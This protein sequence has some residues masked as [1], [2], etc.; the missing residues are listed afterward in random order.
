MVL[1]VASMIGVLATLDLWTQ[2]VAPEML[3]LPS[4]IL[5]T[6]GFAVAAVRSFALAR[7]GGHTEGSAAGDRLIALV[8]LFVVFAMTFSA[9]TAVGTDGWFGLV[10]Y[11]VSASATLEVLLFLNWKARPLGGDLD[12]QRPLGE[13]RR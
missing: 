11:A 5:L 7:R 9:L 1:A 2:T 4:N 13:R 10:V 3:S 8:G 12:A 6:A